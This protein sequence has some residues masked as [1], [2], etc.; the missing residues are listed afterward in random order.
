MPTIYIKKLVPNAV[1]PTY[2]SEGSSGADLYSVED[3]IIAPHTHALVSTGI[4]IAMP[5]GIE[6][7]VRPRSGIAL[8]SGVTVLNAPGTIDSDYRGAVKVILINHSEKP[9]EVRRGM[10]IAQMVFGHVERVH[11]E[12]ADEL[13]R[14]ERNDGGFGHSGGTSVGSKE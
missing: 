8:K 9:F 10:R 13:D 6:A 5:R 3:T 7:Q 11:F 2:A 1:T 14:T 12:V 4:A